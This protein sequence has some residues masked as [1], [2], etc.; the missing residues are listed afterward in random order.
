MSLT[1]KITLKLLNKLNPELAHNLV[2]KALALKLSPSTTNSSAPS[3]NINFSGLNL[4]N[5]IGLAAGFDK[6][7]EAIDS[8]SKLGFG[9]LEIGGVTPLP[10]DGNPKP[11]LFRLQKDKA[12]I[13]RF[14]F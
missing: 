5:P 1:E 6:N 13:N 10:Q 9:F 2:I 14:G 11:R 12:I 4:E 7:A 8:L 3:L